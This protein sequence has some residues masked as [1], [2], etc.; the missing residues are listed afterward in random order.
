MTYVLGITG[1]IGMGKSTTAAMFHDAGV[2]VWDADAAVHTLY[3]KG[4]A[5]VEAIKSIA[6]DAIVNDIVDRPSLRTAIL[7]DS[8][9][10]KQIEAA[11]HPLVAQNRQSF[12]DQHVG[13]LSVCDIPLLYETG[14]DNWL[15][16]VLVVTASAEVQRQ[17]VLERPNMSAEVFESI[18]AKQMPD[19]EKRR[20]ADFVI[21]TGKGHDNARAEVLS[22]IKQLGGN[23]A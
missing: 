7:A 15:D 19:A 13:K 20:M 9:L 14:A 1:S 5:G 22:L 23:D 18:L 4:G 8:A 10:L 21:D 3:E 6:P 16:G 12:L 17:R 11:I 2:P